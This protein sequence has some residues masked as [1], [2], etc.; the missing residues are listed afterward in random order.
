ML[1]GDPQLAS[2]KILGTSM[3]SLD[4]EEHARHRRAF[5][6]PFRPKF[7]RE[8]LEAT[9]EDHARTLVAKVLEDEYPE[10]RG[11]L[12]GPL[13]VRTILDVLGLDSVEASDVL[14]WYSAFSE[15]IEILTTGG[16]LPPEI[17]ARLSTL[18]GQVQTAMGSD[19]AGLITQLVADGIL[20]DDEIPAAVAVVM[21]GAIETSEGMIANA[22]WH[23]LTHPEALDRLRDDR[24][25][26]DPAIEESLRLE[27]A[28]AVVDRYTTA[29]V[30]LGGVTIPAG[31]LVTISLLASNR[32]PTV[33]PQPDIFVIDRPNPTQH[34][35][36]ALGPHTCLG[37][38]VA[39]AET[40]AALNAMLDAEDERG[41][42]FA[43]DLK[44]STPPTGLIF[45]KPNALCGQTSLSLSAN[46]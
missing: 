31:D 26:I 10:L 5:V 45:R 12:A 37:L 7:V 40:S 20:R 16:D 41:H 19:D 44:R 36:W 24:S 32:D 33:F 22:F 39:K 17:E 42:R 28:A 6:A 23:L 21:F 46:H 2:R 18:Y 11:G 8:E 3:L 27:P 34:V 9:I 4:G 15:A 13:A 29:D 14:S 1:Y 30:E 25:L 35:T 38:H 43:L